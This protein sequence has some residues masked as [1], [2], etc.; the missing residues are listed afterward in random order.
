[1]IFARSSLGWIHTGSY[2]KIDY[3]VLDRTIAGKLLN[4]ALSPSY[5]Y[6]SNYSAGI[7]SYPRYFS[8][9]ILF[10]LAKPEVSKPCFVNDVT[11]LPSFSHL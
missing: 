7:Y 3:K 11:F 10:E 9:S 4:V 1:M 5:W 8:V 6:P 2:L